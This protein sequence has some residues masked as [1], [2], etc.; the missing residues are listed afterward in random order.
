[1]SLSHSRLQVQPQTRLSQVWFD[2]VLEI[3]L[4]PS[5]MA[6]SLGMM[7]RLSATV[8]HVPRLSLLSSR[9]YA[10]TPT[11]LA[12]TPR[13][14][15]YAKPLTATGPI[16]KARTTTTTTAPAEN[17]T[18]DPS[19]VDSHP[20]TTSELSVSSSEAPPP[21]PT[22]LPESL[23]DGQTDWSKSY[24]GL[25]TQAFSKDIADILL[26]PIDPLD[27]EMKPGK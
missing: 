20:D 21:T 22:F 24:F 7:H 17:N 23:N 6:A 16:A 9:T 1:M 10:V 27:V 2:L 13:A 18:G 3:Y 12:W 11:K 19:I 26:A 8:K 14:S 5:K 4:L 15:S 25:S